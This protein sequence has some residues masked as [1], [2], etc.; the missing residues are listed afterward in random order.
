MSN[1]SPLP[2]LEIPFHCKNT[3][4]VHFKKGVEHFC[5]FQQRFKKSWRF[6]SRLVCRNPG[7]CCFSCFAS[8]SSCGQNVSLSPL[9]TS[10]KWHC[11][12]PSNG[13]LF[14]H[15]RLSLFLPLRCSCAQPHP[16]LHPLHFIRDSPTFGLPN[17]PL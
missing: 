12:H 6:I 1:C 5:F 7:N 14:P 8:A 17:Q 13:T 9:V 4:H 15:R 11:R 10:T 16:C 2:Q 3:K